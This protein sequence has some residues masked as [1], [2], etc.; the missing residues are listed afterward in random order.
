MPDWDDILGKHNLGDHNEPSPGLCQL[1]ALLAI[2]P[3]SSS[4][5]ATNLAQL[6]RNLGKTWG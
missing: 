1:L 2:I 3:L 6:G 5:P 4:L